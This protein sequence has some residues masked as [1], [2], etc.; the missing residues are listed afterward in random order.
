[1]AWCPASLDQII[2]QPRFELLIKRGPFRRQG[3]TDGRLDGLTKAQTPKSRLFLYTVLIT[4]VDREEEDHL[5]GLNCCCEGVDQM[6]ESSC[7]GTC[8]LF[9]SL[10]E[11]MML[12]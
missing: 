9:I 7:S 5:V 10:S 3:R 11:E 12:V 4:D 1:M 8:K 2:T 6:A